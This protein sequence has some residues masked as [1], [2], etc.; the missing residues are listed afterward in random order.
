MPLMFLLFFFFSV[1]HLLPECKGALHST[2]H[3]S[4][5]TVPQLCLTRTQLSKAH[6]TNFDSRRALNIVFSLVN[7]V[8]LEVP[9]RLSCFVS[10]FFFFLLQGTLMPFE[11][12]LISVSGNP[13]FLAVNRYWNPRPHPPPAGA[14]SENP[15]SG[16]CSP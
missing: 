12:V 5:H 4:L 15:P 14:K 10:F 7:H 13:L 1:N 11:R 9:G 8:L 3:F 16:I 6:L 2:G